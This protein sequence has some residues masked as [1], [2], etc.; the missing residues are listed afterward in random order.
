MNKYAG[1]KLIS[2]CM[3]GLF[4]AG[5]AR[6]ESAGIVATVGD[7]QITVSDVRAFMAVQGENEQRIFA[8]NPALMV[9]MIRNEALRRLIL[10][11]GQ[12]AE[13]E[14]NLKV[15]LL[16]KQQ[17]E[18][19]LVD[20]Y[21]SKM[22]NLPEAFPGKADIE[23]IYKNNA[24]K[25]MRPP[26]IRLAQIFL[27]VPTDAPDNIQ[28]EASKRMQSLVDE[29]KSNKLA[30]SE[31]ARNHTLV[32]VIDEKAADWVPESA[33]KG[34]IKAQ[35]DIMAKLPKG[36]VSR[37]VF[38]YNGW[39]ILKIV[40]TAP[41]RMETLEEA[42]PAIAI[43]LRKQLFIENKRAYL[44]EL[45]TKNPITMAEPATIRKMFSETP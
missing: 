20:S 10:A 25:F 7:M 22:A 12:K 30:F 37:P 24:N 13:W 44:Y 8:E 35:V 21:L 42:T 45:L 29:I 38:A 28:K 17:R 14:K 26:M 23:K 19:V 27:P 2:L 1:L 5:L 43:Q 36:N 9:E 3:A 33:L 15:L 32:R 41:A 11:E 16:L 39:N 31:V 18:Q 4:F 40:E 6:A 34:E